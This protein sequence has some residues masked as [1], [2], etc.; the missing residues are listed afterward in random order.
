[1]KADDEDKIPV[2]EYHPFRRHFFIFRMSQHAW[3]EVKQEATAALE[4]I[5][6]RCQGDARLQMTSVD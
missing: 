4:K 3:L 2:A 1:M 5:I 6:G